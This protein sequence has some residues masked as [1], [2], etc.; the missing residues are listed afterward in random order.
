MFVTYDP[1]VRAEARAL[2]RSR[3]PEL[4][5]ASPDRG[6]H[7]DVDLLL[8]LQRTAGN[9]A[10]TLA[11][12]RQASAGAPA[13]QRAGLSDLV[14]GVDAWAL[15]EQAVRASASTHTISEL[16]K[17]E[18]KRYAE[19]NP[20]DGRIL[21]SALAQSPSHYQG[22]ALLAAQSGA[23]AITFGNSIFYRND[24]SLTTFI[25]EMVHIHQY[26]VLGREAFV[27]SYFGASLATIIKRALA[28]EPIDAM[29]SSPHEVQ[30]YDLAAR[31]KR[32]RFGT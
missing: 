14:P 23:A 31:F 8:G 24:P 16:Y 3:A 30:A 12:Q 29:K 9:R 10:V 13:V 27:L 4:A 20:E 5:G 18:L 17:N 19:A 11:L 7:A 22:G 2:R 15:A 21:L 32:W 26:K 25:H 1:G 6:A 28:G